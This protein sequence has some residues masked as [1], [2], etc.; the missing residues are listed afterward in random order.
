MQRKRSDDPFSEEEIVRHREGALKRVLTT[1]H[2]SRTG[3][4]GGRGRLRQYLT[5][6]ERSLE[7]GDTGNWVSTW[8]R[9]S[10]PI[11]TQPI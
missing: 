8:V 2:Q 3:A 7:Q 1:P 5:D 4:S 10:T 6:R 11:P 9:A